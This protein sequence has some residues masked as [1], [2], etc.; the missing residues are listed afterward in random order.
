METLVQK[1]PLMRDHRYL[2]N[3]YSN[4]PNP[5]VITRSWPFARTSRGNYVHRPRYGHIYA[6]GRTCVTAWCGQLLQWATFLPVPSP[7]E[8]VCATCEGRAIG[9]GQLT[10]TVITGHEIRFSPR[11]SVRCAFEKQTRGYG[12]VDYYECGAP[13]HFHA[14]KD[15]E[16]L[17]V[18]KVHQLQ[19]MKKG[20]VI[21][22]LPHWTEL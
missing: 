6:G 11:T 1:V 14:C 3:P 17:G 4:T 20:Y 2:D 9:A 19:A 12:Y 18:C 5:I 13:A 21:E 10:S 22:P 16:Y 8:V 15:D 7:D